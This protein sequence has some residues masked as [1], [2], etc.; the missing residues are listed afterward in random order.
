MIFD[1]G[2]SIC[3]TNQKTVVSKENGNSHILHN[4]AGYSVFQYR[5]DGG[6]V[7]DAAGERCDF[8]VEV[9]KPSDRLAY[10]VELKGSDL[11]KALSQIKTTINGFRE[12]LKG[13]QILPRVVVHKTTTHD[14]QGKQYR[15]FKKMYPRLVVKNKKLEENIL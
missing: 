6:I 5:V 1:S 3:Q 8:I 4:H 15:D 14:I 9:Q 12:K 13:Y 10:I 11:N 7:K 2:F